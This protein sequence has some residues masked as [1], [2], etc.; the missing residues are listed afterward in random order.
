MK[1]EEK[2]E[3]E[4]RKQRKRRRSKRKKKRE[5]KKQKR[6]RK[7]RK[8]NKRRK[9]RKRSRKRGGIERERTGERKGGNSDLHVCIASTLC[10]SHPQFPGLG[11]EFILKCRTLPCWQH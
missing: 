11:Y 10:M 8:E 4:K 2:K 7:K 3:W 9:N 6:K 5:E 1:D